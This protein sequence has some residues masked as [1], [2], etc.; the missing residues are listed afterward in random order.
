MTQSQSKDLTEISKLLEKP[1]GRLLNNNQLIEKGNNLSLAR[2]EMELTI[3]QMKLLS[4]GILNLPV[5]G[6]TATFT[7]KDFAEFIE[8]YKYDK[9]LFRKDVKKIEGIRFEIM[10]EDFANNESE[11]GQRKSFSLIPSSYY[12]DGVIE[13]NFHPMLLSSLQQL[14]TKYM[15]LDL[16]MM[17][18]FTS[19]H[20]WSL[21]EHLKSHYG[22][23]HIHL[24]SNEVTIEELKKIFKIEN[25]SGYKYFGN[26]RSKVLDIAV[27]EINKYTDL[28]VKYKLKTTSGRISSV[29]FEWTVENY[30]YSATQNKIDYIKMLIKE[31]NA[32]EEFIED[33][34]YAVFR[35][36]F[37]NG[38]DY[39][40]LS[41]NNAKNIIKKL[42]NIIAEL[43]AKNDGIAEKI[44]WED[45]E[46][47]E[48][49]REMTFELLQT[50]HNLSQTTI[51]FQGN[52]LFE[53]C[54]NL[55]LKNISENNINNMTSVTKYIAKSIYKMIEETLNN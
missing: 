27:S 52:M 38:I 5:T 15:Q 14:S 35:E 47:I 42:K 11:K 30:Q 7:R 9:T 20:S 10:D 22:N 21:Y 46:T 25:K 26:I 48:K 19:V 50:E 41:D 4:F 45:K 51:D 34:N 33:E 1:N 54:L 29:E 24:K 40:Q 31:L 32:R 43:N 12:E 17:K 36:F 49:A 23:K 37:N 6:D 2:M 55:A 13:F 53:F 39:T 8:S 44:D 18:Q 3:R 16:S 28:K